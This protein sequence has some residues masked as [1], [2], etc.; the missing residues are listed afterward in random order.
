MFHP[1]YQGNQCRWSMVNY[2]GRIYSLNCRFASL[3]LWKETI[4]SRECSFQKWS[5]QNV[6]VHTRKLPPLQ[7]LA[8]GQIIHGEEHCTVPVILRADPRRIGKKENAIIQGRKRR[9]AQS[10]VDGPECYRIRVMSTHLH[11]ENGCLLIDK[12]RHLLAIIKLPVLFRIDSLATLNFGIFIK[13]IQIFF[14]LSFNY[15]DI[16]NRESIFELRMFF[17]F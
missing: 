2:N 1:I 6:Y 15:F 13:G 4:S 8:R 14:N 3:R 11:D 12:R 10:V 5:N 17:S 9:R 16:R 7:R